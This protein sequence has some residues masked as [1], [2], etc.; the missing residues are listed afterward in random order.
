MG[1]IREA[2]HPNQ[3]SLWE[4]KI[5]LGERFFYE[6]ITNPLPINMKILKAMKPVAARPRPLPLAH[7]SHVRTHAPAAAHVAATLPAVR[8]GPGEGEE[9]CS[10]GFPPGLSTRV[11]EN[12]KRLA[13]PVLSHGHRGARALAIATAYRT[14]TTASRGIALSRHV[15]Y[16]RAAS[17]AAVVMSA[18][19][20][21]GD[22]PPDQEWKPPM[23]VARYILLIAVGARGAAGGGGYP[24]A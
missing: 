5:Q 4:S 15:S 24:G 23:P 21:A 8:R 7:L 19:L 13:G 11:K 22:S 9:S 16:Q 1:G 10:A 12:Q 2:K 17:A 3:A 18:H 14:V 6:I 20:C